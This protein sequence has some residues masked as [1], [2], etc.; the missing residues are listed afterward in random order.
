MGLT[1]AKTAYIYALI[2]PR[3]NQVRYVGR[4]VNPDSRLYQHLKK[5]TGLAKQLWLAELKAIGL[6]PKFEILEIV[7]I[8][9]EKI[10][11]QFWISYHV[12]K[13]ASLTNYALNHLNEKS[14][15]YAAVLRYVGHENEFTKPSQ[16]VIDI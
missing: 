1:K 11:E 13:G 8:K 12:Y 5:S 3:D 10:A 9:R 16:L 4:T 2:D 14:M 15:F 6:T 7:P